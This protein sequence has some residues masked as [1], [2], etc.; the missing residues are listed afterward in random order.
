MADN[1]NEFNKEEASID[2]VSI[3]I[4]CYE[5]AEKSFGKLLEEAYQQGVE[6]YKQFLAD[7][8]KDDKQ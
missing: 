7:S 8:K 1:P 3:L 4:E 5:F 2:Y 6:D